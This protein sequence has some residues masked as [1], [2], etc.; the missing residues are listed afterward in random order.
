MN[1]AN[2]AINAIL[3]AKSTPVES[4]LSFSCTEDPSFFFTSFNSICDPFPSST[5]HNSPWWRLDSLVKSH[6]SRWRSTFLKNG[7][8]ILNK[9]FYEKNNK[10]ENADKSVLLVIPITLSHILVRPGL[11]ALANI[12]L[13]HVDSNFTKK[14]LKRKIL[15]E[16]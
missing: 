8:L 5:E 3:A 14:G 12:C 15:Q 4:I 10:Q 7:A 2:T 13:S 16:F 11:K 6:V 1:N 9:P